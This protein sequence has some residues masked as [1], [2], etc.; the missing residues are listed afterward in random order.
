[1]RS[2][3]SPTL[4][5]VFP[6]IYFLDKSQAEYAKM[7]C[8]SN[9]NLHFFLMAPR[10]VQNRLYKKCPL[11]TTVRNCA[12]RKMCISYGLRNCIKYF[13]HIF[14]TAELF[15]LDHWEVL[16]MAV[17]SSNAKLSSWKGV[18]LKFLSQNRQLKPFHWKRPL[19]RPNEVYTCQSQADSAQVYQKWP[20]N[21]EKALEG[22]CQSHILPLSGLSS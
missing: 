12:P 13:Q 20:R 8:Q 3:L 4:P 15:K 5:S 21:I 2:P 7:E 14:T 9:F 10:V 1:M 19:V 17:L 16:I 18:F 6:I 11:D 22:L